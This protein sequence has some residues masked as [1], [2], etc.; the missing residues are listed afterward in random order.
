LS[1]CVPWLSG[2]SVTGDNVWAQ[3]PAA[4]ADDAPNQKLSSRCKNSPTGM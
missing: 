4:R 3:P 2:L 1:A